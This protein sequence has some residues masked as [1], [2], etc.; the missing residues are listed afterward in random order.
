KKAGVDLIGEQIEACFAP[1]RPPY[2]ITDEGF[3]VW[4]GKS[5][6]TEAVYDLSERPLLHPRIVQGGIADLPLLDAR[7]LLFSLQ[8]V[9][10][11]AWVDAWER[12]QRG[13]A[14]PPLADSHAAAPP[15]ARPGD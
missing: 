7:R 4:P 10:W 5:Y 15:P 6:E 11:Q 8:P 9:T 3:V 13:E 14:P 1:E 2:A 12:D